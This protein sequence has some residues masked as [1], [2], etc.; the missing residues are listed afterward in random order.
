MTKD[1]LYHL[2]A[3]Q[4]HLMRLKE[5]GKYIVIFEDEKFQFHLMRL[6]DKFA[7]SLRLLTNPFQFHLMRLKVNRKSGR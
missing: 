7:S 2:I 3:F 4:F 6:K 1:K 5:S